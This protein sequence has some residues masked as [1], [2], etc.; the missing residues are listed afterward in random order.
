[1]RLVLILSLL[2][3]GASAQ[4]QDL[5]APQNFDDVIGE[6]PGSPS[7]VSLSTDPEVWMYLHEQRRHDDPRQA[8]RRKA[9]QQAAERMARINAM[10][11]YG[12]SNS[13]P[14]A[15][16]TPFMSFYSPHWD[17]NSGRQGTWTS[18]RGNVDIYY[19]QPR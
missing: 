19:L 11:W 3:I 15:E 17:G 1:M 18:N 16:V 7:D 2:V 8:V 12:Y 5:P 13:R 6:Y 4:A 10:R 14:R 9:E